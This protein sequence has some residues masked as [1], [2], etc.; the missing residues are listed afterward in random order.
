[1]ADDHRA[2]PA[3]VVEHRDDVLRHRRHAVVAR[4]AP[5]GIAEAAHVHGDHL[6]A[7]AERLRH[8]EPVPRK[9]GQAVHDDDRR[10]ARLS[11]APVVNGELARAGARAAV[12]DGHRRS[13]PESYKQGR[14]PI[15]A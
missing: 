4:R 1:M 6:A 13:L 12:R 7:R 14:T 10:L 15:F 3:G 9:V 2:L 11:E 5:V 8:R